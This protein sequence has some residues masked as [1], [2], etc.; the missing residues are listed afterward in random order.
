MRAAWLEP[1]HVYI[2][3]LWVLVQLQCEGT[4]IYILCDLQ[5]VFHRD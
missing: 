2:P 4:D 5:E 3:Q 1:L